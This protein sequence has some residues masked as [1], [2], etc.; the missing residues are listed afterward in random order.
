MRDSLNV[1]KTH[2]FDYFADRVWSC[3]K[4]IYIIAINF[5]YISLL[6]RGTTLKILGKGHVC[7]H[8]YLE[9]VSETSMLVRRH[10]DNKVGTFPIKPARVR[11]KISLW[12]GHVSINLTLSAVF[13]LKTTIKRFILRR[14]KRVDEFA[15]GGISMVK[16]ESSY[17][18]LKI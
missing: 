16:T 18:S 2:V 4:G 6:T 11:K 10:S 13:M 8:L 12:S 5:I 3:Q 17:L 15:F 14:R 1:Y 9:N 7:E